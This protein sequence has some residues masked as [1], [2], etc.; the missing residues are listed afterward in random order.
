M[1]SKGDAVAQPIPAWKLG[2]GWHICVE[3]FPSPP[4]DKQ[5]DKALE[6]DKH[7]KLS[8]EIHRYDMHVVVLG[9]E[10]VD[11]A[12]CLK[13]DFL[14]PSPVPPAGLTGRYRV[15]VDGDDGWPRKAFS[16]RDYRNLSIQ[17]FG[18]ARL[19]TVAPEGYP[20]EVLPLFEPT[21]SDGPKSPFVLNLTNDKEKGTRTAILR[22]GED[23]EVEI[24]QTWKEGEKWWQEYERY[25]RGRLDLR[26]RI[27]PKLIAKAPDPNPALKKEEPANRPTNAKPA[28]VTIVDHTKNPLRAD[29]RLQVN[30]TINLR[31]PNVQDVLSH[32]TKAT[33]LSFTTEEDADISAVVFASINWVNTPVWSA[34]DHLAESSKIKGRWEKIDGGYRLETSALTIQRPGR[35]PWVWIAVGLLATATLAGGAFVVYRRRRQ[36]SS[37]NP[38]QNNPP[39]ATAPAKNKA[40]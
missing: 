12:N 21:E 9:T 20:I 10:K 15:C 13:I 16:F 4:K 39:N 29:P 35:F 26:A 27:V 28:P 25:R 37:L 24:R 40:L 1:S 18:K 23:N 14:I 22:A 11:G 36:K 2:D 33:G 31:E 17:Q 3:Y 5:A 30:V 6:N 7:R 8:P 19:L 34:M 38:T 32:F